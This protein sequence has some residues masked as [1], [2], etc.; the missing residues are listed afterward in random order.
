LKDSLNCII[1][2]WEAVWTDV[3]ELG[4]DRKVAA[5]TSFIWVRQF[6]A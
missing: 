4:Q 3:C 1:Q 5:V 2:T 6:P